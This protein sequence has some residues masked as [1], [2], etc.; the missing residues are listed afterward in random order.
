MVRDWPLGYDVLRMADDRLADDSSAE[1]RKSFKA[2]GS[3]LINEPGPLLPRRSLSIGSTGR[4]KESRKYKLLAPID[5]GGMGELFLAEMK[6]PNCP[7]RFVVIK[8]LLADLIDDDKYVSMFLSEA[9][10]MSSLDHRNIVRVFDMPEIE[11]VKCLAMEYVR[12]RNV[13]QLLARASDLQR[14]V[15]PEVTLKIMAD[16]LRGLE[17]AHNRTLEDGTELSLVHRD[18]TPGNVL[19]SF[20]GDVKLTDFGIAKSQFSQVQ[21]TVGI[22]KG[23]ARYLAP[24]QILGEAATPRSDIFSSALVVCEMLTGVPTFDFQSVPKTLYAIVNGDRAN[25]EHV[26]GFH[27]PQL[28][29]LLNRALHT[30]P[31]KR[32]A[33]AREFKEGIEEAASNLGSPLTRAELGNYLHSLFRSDEDPLAGFLDVEDAPTIHGF[34]NIAPPQT[35]LESDLMAA[36]EVPNLDIDAAYVDQEATVR[37]TEPG[38]GETPFDPEE[39]TPFAELAVA[40]SAHQ[41][42]PFRDASELTEVGSD[43]FSSQQGQVDEALRVL[44]WLQSKTNGEGEPSVPPLDTKLPPRQ[45]SAAQIRTKPSS[46][47][48][49]QQWG[50]AHVVVGVVLGALMGV[51]LTLAAQSAFR[52]SPNQDPSSSTSNPYAQWH[53]AKKSLPDGG[54]PGVP[55]EAKPPGAAETRDPKVNEAKGDEP[56][57]DEPKGDEPKG[58]EPKGD[59][60]KGNEPKGDEPQTTAAAANPTPEVPVPKTPKKA[61]EGRLDVLSPRNA[62]VRLDGHWLKKRV[63]IRGLKLK[64]GRHRL[65]VHRGTY[66]KSVSFRV[67]RSEHW[68]MTRRLR[69]VKG[70]K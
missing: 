45:Q 69:R 55:M 37:G 63:P 5:R 60:P 39:L 21:T 3:S 34:P 52:R 7:A 27:A 15:P 50:T 11:N 46:Q 64:P 16:I 70:S 48:T 40:E 36:L 30:N 42:S 57:G 8:R 9:K 17:Y 28:V 19:V 43:T 58:D 26:L 6:A 10:V 53:P 13:Q 14:S 49:K 59:E 56:K 38:T 4:G 66:R 2:I 32:I 23:K 22:V 47:P 68:Q 31:D 41:F 54:T 18:V 65:S 29:Q 12:G 44:A 25:L 33:S 24:E 62:R 67:R 51:L 20:D 35:N 61:A 1:G